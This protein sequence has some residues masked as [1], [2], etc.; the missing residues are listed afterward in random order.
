VKQVAC[1]PVAPAPFCLFLHPGITDP[2]KP[3]YSHTLDTLWGTQG[4]AA[5]TRELFDGYLDYAI[6]ASTSDSIGDF[7]FDLV[8]PPL[9]QINFI[10]IYVPPEFQFLGPSIEESIWTDITNDYQYIFSQVL[11]A[12]DPIAPGWTRITIGFDEW[13]GGLMTINPGT[14]HIRFFDVRAPEVAGLYH[15][16][17]RYGA[18]FTYAQI[19]IGAGNYPVAI[20]KQELN[21]ALIRVEVRAHLGIAPPLVSGS[22]LAEGTTPEGRPVS[23]IGYWAGVVTPFGPL[24]TRSNFLFN[25]FVAGQIGA[26]YG[27]WIFGAA[28]GTYTLTAQASGYNPSTTDRF[29]LDPGQSYFTRM[30]I[31][32]SP[33]V[34]VTIWSKHGTGAIPWGNLWQPPYG[35][36]NPTAAPNNAFPW[37]RRDVLIEL[38]DPDGN[39]I[40][41]WAS[42]NLPPAKYIPPSNRLVG[43]HDD[44]TPGWVAG[45]RRSGGTIPTATSYHALLQDN[46]DLLGNVR[47]YPSTQFD[48]HVPWA[49]GDYIAGMPNGQYTVEAFVTGYIMDEADAFQRSF[50][51]TGTAYALQ[52]DLRRSNWIETVMHLPAN[53]FLSG[54]TTVSLFA[55]D[56]DGNERAAI[57]FI[58]DDTPGVPPGPVTKPTSWDGLIDGADASRIAGFAPGYTGGIVMEGWNAVFPNIGTY[59]NRGVRM[60]ND[61]VRKD[62]GLNPTASTHTAGAVSLAGNPYTIR[63]NMADM[64]QPYLAIAG[65]GWYNIVGADPVVSIFLCNSPAS[66]SFGIANAWVFISLRSVDFQVPAHSRPWT[67]PGSEVW[68]EFV[69][70]ATGTAVDWLDPTL[71]GLIQDPGMWGP[72]AQPWPVFPPFVG[73]FPIVGGPN[74]VPTPAAPPGVFG[75]SPFDMDNVNLPG[76]HEE[77]GVT[78]YG[79]DFTSPTWMYGLPIFR[80][81]LDFRPTRLPPGEYTYTA[82]TH[83]YIMRRSFPVQLPATGGA[84]IEADMI[85]GGQIR[86]VMNFNHE[87]IT[88]PFNGFIRVEVFDA[89]DTLVGASIYGMAEPNVFTQLPTG[90][91]I[92]YDPV[93]TSTGGAVRLDHKL[94]VGPAQGADVGL[95][96]INF[97]STR[98]PV[99]PVP[100]EVGNGQRA[101]TSAYFYGAPRTT[102]APSG[103][104]PAVAFWPP[105]PWVAP[106]WPFVSPSDA[107]RVTVPAGGV[108][109]FDIYGFYWY[110]GGPARTWAGGWPTVNTW[111][112]VSAYTGIQWDTGIKG[113]VDIP[114]WA[115][116]GGGLYTVKVWA[117]DPR[118]PDNAYEAAGATDDWRMYAMGWPLENI[119]VPWGGSVE[120][121]IA[122]NNMASLRGTVRWFDMYGNLRP[123]AWAQVSASP[124]PATDTYPA[125]SSGNGAVGAGVADPAGAFIMWLPAGAHDVSVSTAQAPQVWSASAPTVNAEYTVVVSSGWVGG[126]D[127]QLSGSGV[128]IP[129]LPSAVLPLGLFAVLAASLWLLRKKTAN[130]PVLIK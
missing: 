79:S 117:F 46:W 94:V 13:W 85:Q 130:V 67:F 43:L 83:G 96:S 95:P 63:L 17:I 119:E 103:M 29:T 27:L 19:D 87:G 129:E 40:A 121:F 112:G 100:P 56:V 71:Y 65:T 68:V 69:D 7:Q 127:T 114:G 51:L 89:A 66:L 104:V 70:A 122:M 8:I 55:E 91:Y 101:F 14:Y 124:G 1:A 106:S 62:Y 35:T 99:F 9:T 25:S 34:S 73:G 93:Y 50:T 12:Y 11:R 26:V 41:W 53:V 23:A 60:A 126:G 48:G 44:L 86:V 102:W 107:N 18:G 128:P 49:T 31:F 109:G 39:M 72:P 24:D 59:N 110:H 80:A 45:A 125:Y 111:P 33:D 105:P 120:L 5:Q 61:P 123:L 10:Q 116:S 15:F 6:L 76:R 98:N 90:G 108:E 58:T 47:G 82:Y 78:Y 20:V 88:T 81:M 22:V 38:Y 4:G 92:P 115:G 37:P 2:Y 75:V 113:T 54:P 97:P 74:F 32:D 42:N 21:P 57:A 36:N 28:A 118:G 64:G 84:D 3:G 16:K 77:L 52:F 30:V